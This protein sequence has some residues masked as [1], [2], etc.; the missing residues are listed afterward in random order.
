[1]RTTVLIAVA[2]VALAAPFAAPAAARADTPQ[3]TGYQPAPV[4]APV[5]PGMTQTQF[6]EANGL[7]AAN[8]GPADGTPFSSLP[9]GTLAYGAQTAMHDREGPQGDAVSSPNLSR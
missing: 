6:A 7:K 9:S 8:A 5:G 3:W 2:A 1:M 4:P